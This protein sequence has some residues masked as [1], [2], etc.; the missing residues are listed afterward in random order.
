MA[1][2]KVEDIS[3]DSWTNEAGTCEHF[4]KLHECYIM[5]ENGKI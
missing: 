4:A 2:G 3:S 1:E 5:V